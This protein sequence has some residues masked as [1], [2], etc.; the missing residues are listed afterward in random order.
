[1]DIVASGTFHLVTAAEE[2]HFGACQAIHYSGNNIKRCDLG[3][4][5]YGREC[6]RYRVVV[7]KVTVPRPVLLTDV[8][9]L[10]GKIERA[11][12]NK[13]DAR[14]TAKGIDRDGSVVAREAQ[15]GNA[16]GRAEACGIDIATGTGVRAV[17]TK[18][19]LREGPVPQWS[20]FAFRTRTSIKS[21]QGGVW[22]MTD[23]AD[24]PV[25]PTVAAKIVR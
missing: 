15:L 18:G 4:L 24:F 12:S 5:S 23:N 20:E 1:M 7:G 22:R 8:P 2:R 14:T 25:R 17:R 9:V 21:A 16:R 13:E 3:I 19:R 6:E 11:V 10:T